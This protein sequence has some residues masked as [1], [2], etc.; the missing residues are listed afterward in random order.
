MKS[1]LVLISNKYLAIVLVLF[2][3][4]FSNSVL[5]EESDEV[6]KGKDLFQ[7]KGCVACHTI[8]GGKLSGP[9]LEGVTERREEEWLKKWMKSPDTMVFTDPI[10]KEMLAEYMVPMPNQGLTDQEVIEVYSYLKFEDSKK[11]EK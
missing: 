1:I 7:S 6:A 2:F 5:S 10:A 3:I 9:D 4:G 11:K 8:G